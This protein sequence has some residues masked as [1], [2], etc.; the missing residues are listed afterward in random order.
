M[1]EVFSGEMILILYG[2]RSGFMWLEGRSAKEIEEII[3]V[4]FVDGGQND[5]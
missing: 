4:L 2:K 1:Y 5:K 3:D